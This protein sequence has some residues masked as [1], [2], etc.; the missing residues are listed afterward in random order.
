MQNVYRGFEVANFRNINSSQDGVCIKETSLV[1]KQIYCPE[2]VLVNGEN[3]HLSGGFDGDKYNGNIT[4]VDL[5]TINHDLII[6]GD[7]YCFNNATGNVHVK[8]SNVTVTGNLIAES[9]GFYGSGNSYLN[10]DSNSNLHVNGNVTLKGNGFS[11]SNWMYHH[12][13]C[14]IDGIL[15]VDGDFITESYSHITLNNN[16]AEIIVNG[17]FDGVYNETINKGVIEVGGNITDVKTA[18]SATLI[19]NGLDKQT[20]DGTDYSIVVVNNP[21][22]VTFS[23]AIRVSTLFNHKGNQFTLYSNGNGSSF[24]DYDGDGLKDNVDPYPTVGNPC[25]ISISADNESFGTVDS[26]AIN[27][28]GGSKVTITASPKEKCYFV[29]WTDQSGQV[30]STENPYTFIAKTNQSIVAVFAKRSRN[31][32]TNVENGYITTPSYMVEVDS[33]VTFTV[34]PNQGYVIEDGSLKINGTTIEN[35]SFIMPDEDVVISAV[36]AR[37]ENYFN[38]KDSINNAKYYKKSDYTTESYKELTKAISVAESYLYNNVSKEDSEYASGTIEVAINHLERADNKPTTTYYFINNKSWHEVY[39]YT[40]YYELNGAATN[41]K[42]WPGEKMNLV[43]INDEGY[44]VYSIDVSSDM[45]YI[46]FST[47]SSQEQTIDVLFADYEG[48]NAFSLSDNM[49]NN[50]YL[51]KGKNYSESLFVGHSLSLGGNIGINFYINVPDEDVNAGRV[52]VNFAW[53]VEGTKKTY[54][55]ALGS[56]DKYELGYKASCPVPVA[57]MTYDVTATIIVNDIPLDHTDTYSAQKYAKV[58]LNN[59]DSFKDKYIAAENKKGR[60]GEQRYSDLITLIQTMLDYGSKAQIVFN[61]DT[62]HPANEGN[63]Y[64]SDEDYPVSAD[65]VTVSE[66]K[67]NMDLTEYGLRYK[68]STVV[69]LSETSIRHYYYVDDWDCF[70]KI[71]DS[72]TFDGETVTY[73]EK[74]DAIYFEKKGVSA[75]NLDTPYKLT[76]K[77]ESCK[78]AVNDYIRHCLESDT[79]SDN[80]KA[81]V[82]ATYRYNVAANVFFEV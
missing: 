9:I 54:S 81:L 23:K 35:N 63:E 48:N 50:H 7:L 61:R 42:D 26:E 45:D 30:L 68:G 8:N 60:N 22:G 18:D 34:V 33:L 47:G 19:L 77:D 82:R 12:S 52:K 46:I 32:T 2:S 79:V 43:G 70:N 20:I 25:S 49:Q 71:K 36:C 11:F 15:S 14:V 41:S 58:I 67:M 16:Q 51:V 80:T 59:E 10:I 21:N 1:S 72:I 29:K 37:N 56:Y 28:T 27:T 13:H 38:L 64:F 78:F 31:I 74:D 66:E 6:D 69:Y 53:N 55:V 40:W 65:M 44:D 39:A 76:F 62:E 3:I 73:T 4:L 75:P 24:V 17:N 5:S 57:E